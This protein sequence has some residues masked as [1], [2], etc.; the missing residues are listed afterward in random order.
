MGQYWLPV[1]IDKHEYIHPHQLASG[2][3]L[4]E[5]LKSH[6]G[7]ALVILLAN[8]PEPR[9]GG[10][11]DM[12]NNWHGPERD[13]TKPKYFGAPG[14]MPQDYPSIARQT[15][16][17]WVGDR[18]VLV[19]DYAQEDDLLKVIDAGADY[20]AVD[21]YDVCCDDSDH[22]GHEHKTTPWT[23]ITHLVARVIEHECQ[24]KFTGDG[25]RTFERLP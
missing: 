23:N 15:I 16:G 6:V 18:V 9:G 8:M 24:G 21:I 11:F 20:T 19:G 12:D 5:Q 25:W 3:K 13:M 17:R 4:V 14:P 10:D 1:N 7:S 2:L 22:T